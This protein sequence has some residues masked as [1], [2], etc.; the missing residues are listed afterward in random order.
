MCVSLCTAQSE[1]LNKE[2]IENDTVKLKKLRDNTFEFLKNKDTILF[3]SL[4]R[5]LFNLSSKMRD[6][7]ALAEYHWNKAVFFKEK[8]ILDS[9]YYQYSKAQEYYEVV[10]N[11]YY[12][13]KMLYNMAFVRGRLRDYTGSEILL[14]QSISKFESLNRYK[15]LYKSYNELGLVS[16]ELEE[17]DKAI[18]YYDKALEYLDD[19][20]DQTIFKEEILNNIGL[21]YQKM[22]AH[23]RAI[24]Y[25]E[26]ALD[27][28]NLLEDNPELYA[29]LLDNNAYSKLMTGDVTNL[30]ESF[31]VALRI[32]DSLGIKLGILINKLHLAEYYAFAQDTSRALSYAK[33][34]NLLSKEVFNPRDRMTSLKLLS[35]FDK[36]NKSHYLKKYIAVSDSLQKEDRRVRNKFTRISYETDKY[37]EETERLSQQK[38]RIMIGSGIA[39]LILS[40]SYF[41]IR[42]RSK[43]KELM[44]EA[45]QQKNNEEIYQLI[46]NQQAKLEEGRL[47]ERTRISEEL[48]DGVLGKLFGTRLGIGFLELKG[49]SNTL[50]KH[51]S[52]LDEIQ[53]IEKEIRTI[54]HELKSEILSTK[55]GFMTIIEN[56]VK[57]QSTIGKYKYSI[58]SETLIYWDE[59]QDKAKFNV[60]RILQESLFNINKY[61]KA[62]NVRIDFKIRD[63]MLNLT[64]ADDGVGFDVK[65]NKKGIGITNMLARAQRLGGEFSISSEVTKG[66]VSTVSI[67]V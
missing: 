16:T 33:E 50:E 5:E 55:L 59:I 51:E 2:V 66:T 1:N 61:S 14:F 24:I 45:E 52:F 29:I 13:G 22:D 17:F 53:S 10:G 64:V 44:F 12:S 65:N 57:E 56:L 54:S 23:K 27:S 19:L 48:H 36:P 41:L 6:T 42:Q 49:D 18:F 62:K 25:F 37:V 31:F 30:P 8:G 39:I 9:C 60:Y 58:N 40:L 4:N 67:P 43:N 38:T 21:I 28:K 46:L 47:Q 7:S 34:A 15:S 26:K 35:E 20:N 11:D 63:K 3:K 32:R